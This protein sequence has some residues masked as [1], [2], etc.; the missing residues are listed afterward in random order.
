MKIYNIAAYY[1]RSLT[2][3]SACSFQLT[4]LNTVQRE[5]CFEKRS[6]REK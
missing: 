1:T 6:C 4:S 2:F 3:F 5:E